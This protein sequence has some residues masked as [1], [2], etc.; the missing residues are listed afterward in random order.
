MARHFIPFGI[1]VAVAALLW[2]TVGWWG[3]WVIFPWIG[4]WI[5]VGGL[6]VRNRKGKKK[7]L[8]RRLSILMAAPVFLVFL[9]T[10]ERENLQLEQLV[11]YLAAG[12]YTRV[13]VH[14]AVAKVFGPLVWGRGFCG[15]ACWT[16]AVLDWLPIRRNRPIPRKYTLL[17]IPV[18]VASIALPLAFVAAGYDFERLHVDESLGKIHQLVWFLAGNGVYYVAAVALAFAF[19][20]KRAFCK[21][22][23]P[24]SLVMT[25]TT[26]LALLKRKPSGAECD[27]C[28]L[29]NARCPMDVDV[30]GA[31]RAGKKVTDTECIYCGICKQVCPKG[32]IE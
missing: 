5:T 11:F 17:R 15:W 23:C 20:K 26:R 9:G 32:A 12:V 21:V 13:V 31:I 27:E 19:Q 1:G 8:G 14:Y 28:G 7:D 3:F 25:P 16:A 22:A 24:V 29:C 2:L 10:V 30:M 4:A 18:A 6:V